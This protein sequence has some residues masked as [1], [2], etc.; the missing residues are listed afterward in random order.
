M[1]SRSATCQLCLWWAWRNCRSGGGGGDTEGAREV[2]VQMVNANSASAARR[3]SPEQRRDCNHRI[4]NTRLGLVPSLRWSVSVSQTLAKQTSLSAKISPHG[5]CKVCADV[6]R[7]YETQ[8]CSFVTQ[9]V[10]CWPRALVLH[11]ATS[12]LPSS[13][14]GPQQ[15]VYNSISVVCYGYVASASHFSAAISTHMHTRLCVRAR[16]HRDM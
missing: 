15:G 3:K 10:G 7:V 6:P 16:T 2:G 13:F 5:M 12:P 9:N 1:Q 14:T 4:V 8:L 11:C